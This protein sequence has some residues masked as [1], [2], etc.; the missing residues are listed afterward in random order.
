MREGVQHPEYII[1]DQFSL[2]A[3]V[4]RTTPVT[5]KLNAIGEGG[6]KRRS[7]SLESRK[8]NAIESAWSIASQLLVSL[9]PQL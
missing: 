2:P 9:W 6:T 7:L 4:T 3:V 1:R 5:T 8:T